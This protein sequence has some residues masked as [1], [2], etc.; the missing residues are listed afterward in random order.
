MT[1]S[2]DQ[3]NCYAMFGFQNFPWAS[4]LVEYRLSVSCNESDILHVE[5]VWCTLVILHK[6]DFAATLLS[7]YGNLAIEDFYKWYQISLLQKIT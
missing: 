4:D 1:R 7:K 2:H 6:F 3:K 5:I